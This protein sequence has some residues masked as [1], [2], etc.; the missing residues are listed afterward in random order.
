[1]EYLRATLKEGTQ[2]LFENL[3][4]NLAVRK[5]PSGLKEWYGSFELP[6]GGHIDPGGPYRLIL[7][8][9]RSGNILISDILIS[10]DL[11]TLVH[12]LGSGPL[13]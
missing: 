6:G 3:N 8:D 10:S 13:A 2:I 9:G 1:M 5:S 7:E 11:P 4:I 12:F